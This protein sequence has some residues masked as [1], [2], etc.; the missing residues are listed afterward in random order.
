MAQQD[1]FGYYDANGAAAYDAYAYRENTAEELAVPQELPQEQPRH[2][3]QPRV[4]AK[5][6]VAPFTLFGMMAAALM[7]ILV[8][9]GYVQLYERTTAVS[10]LQTQ[11]QDLN[12]QQAQLKSKYEGKINLTDIESRAA[13]LG[14]S[15]PTKDQ[16]VN[17]NLTGS[18]RA[19]IYT[20]K[21]DSV[22]E[23]I[24]G[25]VKASVADLI[26]YLHPSAA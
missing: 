8:L 1:R 17:V 19:E 21:K 22:I 4:K 16:T 6:A 18:D 5:A 10:K 12:Q 11:L 24:V 9:F 13:Q 14:L 20:E 26:A 23:E 7:M 15:S 25:A 3:K 2:K